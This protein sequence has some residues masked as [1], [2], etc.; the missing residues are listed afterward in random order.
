MHGFQNGNAGRLRGLRGRQPRAAAAIAV[1]ALVSL[2]AVARS[3]N[4][5]RSAGDD[6]Q[7]T[8]PSRVAPGDP[9]PTQTVRDI[10][11]LEKFAP[12]EPG[13]FIDP[14]SDPSTPLRV[15]YEVPGEGWS[16]WYGAVKFAE[17]RHVMINITTVVNLVRHGCRDH[18]WAAPPVGPSVD[19]LTVALAD[20]VPRR[21]AGLMGQCSRMSPEN[22]SRCP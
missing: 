1:V 4:A 12:L 18:S 10:M 19:D 7:T 21:R 17:D 3:P 16:Q 22:A 20:L 2:A 15:V 14:D 11:E 13:V 9:G 6:P 5:E 8:G